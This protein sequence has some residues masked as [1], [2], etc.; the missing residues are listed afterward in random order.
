MW[1]R[2]L[3]NRLVVRPLAWALIQTHVTG[4]E[5]T[6]AAGSFI[7]MVNHCNFLDPAA[8]VVSML[9]R[10][11]V[12]F[13]KVQ[14]LNLP[15]AGPLLRWYGVVPVERGEPDV[16]AIHGALKV[17]SAKQ[18]ILLIAPEGTRSYHGRL[19][20]GKNGLAFV[21]LRSGA[22][23]LPVGVSGVRDFWPNVRQLRRTDVEIRIGHPFR[24]RS[25]G[26]VTRETLN[27]MTRQAMYQ[28]AALLP[29]EQWGVY[30]D[31]DNASE[32]YLEF[33]E[34]GRSNL[35]YAAMEPHAGR[36][37]FARRLVGAAE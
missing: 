35:A 37:V 33:L 17:L 9:P 11:V 5:N 15:V 25:R 18:D 16:K 20:T 3:L 27:Q 2:R 34:P 36:R 13:T 28:L 21:A 26:H 29:P 24:L 1:S 8:A 4:A 31:I 32:E 22:I 14:N 7:L 23:I 10:E 6:P 30:A 19:Q 12:L